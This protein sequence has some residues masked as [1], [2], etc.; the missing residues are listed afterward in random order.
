[1]PIILGEFTEYIEEK[2]M[3]SKERNE[4]EDDDFGIPELRKYPI[5]DKKHVEQAIKMFNHVDTKY[6]SELADNLLDAMDKFSISTTTVGKN[7]RLRK[8]IKEDT[9]FTEG[10]ILNDK[11]P[12][13]IKNLKEKIKS[14]LKSNREKVNDA[15]DVID[16]IQDLGKGKDTRLEEVKTISNTCKK[17]NIKIYGY[18]VR[19]ANL[20]GV[21]INTYTVITSFKDYILSLIFNGMQGNVKLLYI[22]INYD[23]SKC[24]IP[25]DVAFNLLSMIP[26]IDKIKSTKFSIKISALT[27]S[28]DNS[29]PRVAHRYSNKYSV[30]KNISGTSIIVSVLD[31]A[32]ES[33]I[34]GAMPRQDFQPD[35]VYI[36]NY[37]MKNTFTNNLAI[38]KDKMSDIYICKD[39]KPIHVSL[40][41]FNN[42]ATDIKMYR[43]LTDVNFN[44]VIKDSKCGLDFYN[45]I[46]NEKSNIDNLDSDY[47]FERVPS[48]LDELNAIKECIISSVP[49]SGVVHEIYCP[50]IPLLE[51]NNED[52]VIRYFRDINGVF[53]ENINTLQRS[54]SYKTIEEIPEIVINLLSGF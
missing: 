27:K 13:D 50:I 18:T 32:K 21:E 9:I 43:C 39:E 30:K 47:R 45:N 51:M 25:K 46:I 8:Y 4:L 20:K 53:V 31:Y 26:D 19:A 2:A 52:S 40:T 5:N 24:D 7:N 41:D 14:I 3:S 10:L 36:I 17:A 11:T 37:M 44:S 29:Y 35:A 6:E 33:A 12:N 16:T 38:C 22:T 23:K 34:A 15:E 48:Y 42:M 49:T 28:I 54:K 1:M